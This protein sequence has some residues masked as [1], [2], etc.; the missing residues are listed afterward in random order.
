MRPIPS[1]WNLWRVGIF[2]LVLGALG[3]CAGSPDGGASRGAARGEYAFWPQFPVE[4]KVQYLRSFGGSGDLAPK[5]SSALERAV[6]G[7]E[8]EQEAMINKPYGVAMHKGRIYVSDLRAGNVV[9]LDLAKKQTRLMGVSGANRL[10]HPVA[11]AVADDGTIYV[12]ESDRGVIAVFDASERYTHAIGFEKFKPVSLAVHG[13][14]L[15]ACDMLGQVVQVFDRASGQRIASIGSVGDGD[16]Q[17]RLPLGVA[18]DR[19]GNVYVSDMMRSR[20]QKFSPDGAYLGGVGTVGDTPGSFARPKHLAVD[21]DGIIYVV[22]AAF[23]NVQM[24][25]DQFRLLLAFGAAGDFPGAMNLPAG[26]CVD[27]ETLAMFLDEVH[28]GFVPKRVIAVAN[29]FGPAKVSLYALGKPREGYAAA[30]FARS[31]AKVATGVGP[32]EETLQMQRVGVEGDA[33]PSASPIE[34]APE[35]AVA[36]K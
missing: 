22:D 7:K 24:F 5:A 26:V 32:T 14:R 17:F 19:I 23:Q 25:D 35:P 33:L 16:G 31:A 36:P 1:Q 11:V 18:T 4:P 29:Q 20:V 12:A 8:V 9:V 10:T 15:Y 34:T 13:E 21:R 30:E 28:P 27:D 6:F 3:G 2:G